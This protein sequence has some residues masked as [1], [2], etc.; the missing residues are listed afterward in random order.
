[1]FVIDVLCDMRRVL[2]AVYGRGRPARW[3]VVVQV[4]VGS[5]ASRYEPDR[6]GLAYRRGPTG[7]DGLMG[8]VSEPQ[9]LAAATHAG[10]TPVQ[11]VWRGVAG[12]NPV[13]DHHGRDTGADTHRAPPTCAA[14]CRHNA[15]HSRSN[16]RRWSAADMACHTCRVP[17]A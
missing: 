7:H 17:A 8:S 15:A 6:A 5:G 11:A 3:L 14:A 13:E 16:T 2:V 12:L 9:P 10:G 4:V 1:M